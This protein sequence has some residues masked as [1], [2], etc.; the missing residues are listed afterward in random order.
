[1]GYNN[2]FQSGVSFFNEFSGK[3][4]LSFNV[5]AERNSFSSIS[6]SNTGNP[7]NDSIRRFNIDSNILKGLA[8][9]TN[10]EVDYTRMRFSMKPVMRK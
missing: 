8:Y 5:F 3:R 4:K 6:A 2:H 9:S 7:L 1:M 10:A